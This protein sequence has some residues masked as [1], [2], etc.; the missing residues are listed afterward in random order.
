MEG[1]DK[2]LETR[3]KAGKRWFS[4]GNLVGLSR[5]DLENMYLIAIG[6]TP[7]IPMYIGEEADNLPPLCQTLFKAL[8]PRLA[9]GILLRS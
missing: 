9:W 3:A 5:K 4:F 7:A 2:L 6:K 1:Y 8:S